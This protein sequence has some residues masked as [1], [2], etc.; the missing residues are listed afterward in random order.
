VPTDD[1]PPPGAH[2]AENANTAAN[3]HTTRRAAPHHPSI[4]SIMTISYDD[5]TVHRYATTGRR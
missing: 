2:P 4:L 3:T 5:L 1:R